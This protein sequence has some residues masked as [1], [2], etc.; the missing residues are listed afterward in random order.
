MKKIVLNVLLIALYGFPFAYYAMYKD[1]SDASMMGYLFMIILVTFNASLS[2]LYGTK[3]A[4]IIGNILSFL[5]SYHFTASVTGPERW[6]GY[7]KPLQPTTLVV[8]VSVL[9]LLPQMIAAFI[10]K[11]KN[12]H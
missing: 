7:F 12:V 5:L 2:A 9:M 1:Y 4:I 3:W 8:V 6:F 10:I 11:R